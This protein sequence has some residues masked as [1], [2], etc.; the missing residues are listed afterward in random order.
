M[1]RI[2]FLV[3]A[4]LP[5]C[6]SPARAQDVVAGGDVARKHCSGC[7]EVSGRPSGILGFAPAFVK[8]AGTKGMT[9]TS[10]EVFLGTPHEV[11][12]NYVLSEREIRDVA[13]YI[14]SL[15]PAAP[16]RAQH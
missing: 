15:R 8:I 11:M 1:R 2:L 13:A 10:V 14:I 4:C 6:L 5:F 9:Q 16:N 12:P 3:A 7:H